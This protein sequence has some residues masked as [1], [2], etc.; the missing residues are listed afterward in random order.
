MVKKNLK[1]KF[2]NGNIILSSITKNDIELL[3]EWKNKNKKSFFYQ[4]NITEAQQKKWFNNYLRQEE[5]Y[6]FMITYK[7]EKIGCIGFRL[8]DGVID[9]YNI[10]L[11][12]KKYGGIGLM[13]EALKLI[14]S[15][16]LDKYNTKVSQASWLARWAGLLGI[17]DISAYIALILTGLTAS[18]QIEEKVVPIRDKLSGVSYIILSIVFLLIIGGLGWCFYRAMTAAGKDAPEQRPDE[19]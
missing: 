2:E 5:D 19:Q 9:L 15:Y 10:I 18:V 12:Y 4:K 6:I 1:L 7:R 14:C 16:V 11:G 8:V 13:S 17:I 3:R